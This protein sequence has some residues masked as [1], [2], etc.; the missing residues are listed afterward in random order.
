MHTGFPVNE[1][2]SQPRWLSVA[3]ASR[4]LGITETAVRK[5]IRNGSLPARGA[6]GSTEVLI[7]V[8]TS[9]QPGSQLINFEAADG[10]IR[11]A[12]PLAA[13]VAELQARLADALLERDRWHA[14][15]MEARAEAR[16]AEV[17]REALERELRLLLSRP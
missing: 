3:R 6:R 15:A 7:S 1:S 5:R 11:Q 12:I 4:L 2:G 9:F 14:L 16:A 13:Q 8:P 10:D 17:A